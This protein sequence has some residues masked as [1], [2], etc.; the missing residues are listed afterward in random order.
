V[1]HLVLAK[2]NRPITSREYKLMLK[3][4]EFDDRQRGIDKFLDLIKS[5]T[6]EQHIELKKDFNEKK[7]RTWYLDTD[8]FELN[9]N[10]FLLRIREEKQ[11]GE[12]ETTLKCRHPDRYMSAAYDLSSPIMNVQ[13]KFEEDITIPFVSKFSLSASFKEN[14]EP[15]L[16]S[17]KDLKSIFSAL[18]IANIDEINS[19]TKVNNFEA[20][21]ISTK[22]GSIQF[23][24][25][26]SAN[27]YLNFWY[28][29]DEDKKA[30]P[31]ILEFTFDYKAKEQTSEDDLLLEDFSHS[32]IRNADIFYLSVQKQ[33]IA[34]HN[35]TKTKTEYVYQYKQK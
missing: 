34:D 21:E 31:I 22:I 19:L 16:N 4:S 23:K 14:K 28:L 15:K 20:R 6:E 13:T 3:P 35:T 9:A 26:K 33:P 10:K 18:N 8:S 12:C 5:Q 1:L 11:T 32:I 25:N 24:E 30:P 27:L 7:R 29:S 2:S 17:F